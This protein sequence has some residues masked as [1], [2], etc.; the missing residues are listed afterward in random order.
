LAID[1][2]TNAA[3]RKKLSQQLENQISEQKIATELA[4]KNAKIPGRA[5]KH[6]MS[7]VCKLIAL[8]RDLPNG[9]E[10]IAK[11]SNVQSANT[12]LDSLNHAGKEYYKLEYSST[13]AKTL[14]KTQEK[15]VQ[16][17]RLNG[18]Q[19]TG[20]KISGGKR[21]DARQIE[22]MFIVEAYK[23]S[24]SHPPTVK[25]VARAVAEWYVTTVGSTRTIRAVA[26]KLQRAKVAT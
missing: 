4:Y 22:A 23:T 19:S 1:W 17:N 13:R 10:H 3:I 24:K 21:R 20:G 15:Y 8:G 9:L 12:L 7:K 5:P 14:R 6:W 16:N 25:P 26:Q 18:S 2:W 11:H